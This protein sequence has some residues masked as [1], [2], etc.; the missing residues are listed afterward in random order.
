MWVCFSIPG[1][2][3]YDCNALHLVNCLMLNKI[4]CCV[5]CGVNTNSVC[6]AHTA[7]SGN[8][9]KSDNKLILSIVLEHLRDRELCIV[10]RWRM[11]DSKSSIMGYLLS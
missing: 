8:R 3:A 5:A 7:V 9:A 10:G 11:D 1:S 6:K 4:L 2:A